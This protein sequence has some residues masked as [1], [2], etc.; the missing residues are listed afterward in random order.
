MEPDGDLCLRIAQPD[1]EFLGEQ[2]VR[3]HNVFNRSFDYCTEIRDY[4]DSP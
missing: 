4:R 1:R 2:R 3:E